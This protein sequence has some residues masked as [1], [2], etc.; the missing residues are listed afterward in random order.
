MNN[1]LSPALVATVAGF[2]KGKRLEKFMASVNHINA[3]LAAGGWLQGGSRKG[4]SGFYQGLED[5]RDTSGSRLFTDEPASAL[6]FAIR[7][8]KV[9][10]FEGVTEVWARLNLKLVK[11]MKASAHVVQ[12]WV[13]LC[14]EVA[15]A[16]EQLDISRPLPVVTEIGLSPRVTATLRECNLDIDLAS[17]KMA[18]LD[19]TL[20]DAVD[21]FGRAVKVKRYFVKWPEGTVHGM[22]RHNRGGCE[23]CGKNIPSR[24]FVALVAK[25]N[26]SGKTVSL[27]V[28]CDCAR[29]IFG[30]KDVG[31]ER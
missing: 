16:R 14:K 5:I 11:P 8:G 30:I 17:I 15:T 9:W 27:W 31:V 13:S 26:R 25:D 22:S 19:F 10:E 21:R 4:E 3:S 18:E 20:E 28:G 23:A 2:M 7:W 6:Y 24:R 1:E 12:A 29:N